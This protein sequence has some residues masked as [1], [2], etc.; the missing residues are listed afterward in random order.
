M[1]ASQHESAPHSL[2]NTTSVILLASFFVL[3][4]YF[5]FK[6][7][8]IDFTESIAPGITYRSLLSRHSFSSQVWVMRTTIRTILS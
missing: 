4:L 6:H 5:L 7:T 1:A 8:R 2:R 3:V